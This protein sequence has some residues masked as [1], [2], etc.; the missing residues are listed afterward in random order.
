MFLRE[1]TQ[2]SRFTPPSFDELVNEHK[3]K[4]FLSPKGV[5]LN[6][7]VDRDLD[8]YNPS[9]PFVLIPGGNTSMFARVEPRA[10][11]GSLSVPYKRKDG[12]WRPVRDIA[13]LNLE[14]PSVV[15]IKGE[16]ILIGVRVW[17]EPTADN[18]F[19]TNYRNEFYRINGDFEEYEMIGY[20]PDRQKDTQLIDLGDDGIGVMTRP[21]L[22]ALR[23]GVLA[24]TII[25][26][27]NDLV[28]ENLINANI[29]FNQVPPGNW[30]GV[31]QLFLLNDG[32]IGVLGHVAKEDEKGKSYAAMVFRYNW[33]AHLVTPI[34]VIATPDD[35]PKFESKTPK[36]RNVIFPSSLVINPG[37]S[38][39]AILYAGLG[40]ASTGYLNT[41]NPFFGL[42]P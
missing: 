13:G 21:H 27:L 6:L 12:L 16:N 34:E 8:C 19:A 24:F 5:I 36:H 20:G 10:I 32:T 28:P 11:E 3:A 31:N 15:N 22:D 9:G 39:R 30:V 38:S 35:F 4:S 41:Y 18:P 42:Y 14:D 33:K 17:P 26:S 37:N 29:I 25:E 1:N 23:R 40:D 2:E 7:P